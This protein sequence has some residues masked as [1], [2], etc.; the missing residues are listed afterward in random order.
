[1]KNVLI[2]TTMFA[3]AGCSANPFKSDI[4][5]IEPSLGSKSVPTWYLETPDD[6][7]TE[8]YAA[9]TGKADDMQ[10]SMD[11][12]LHDAK[13]ILGDKIG[14]QVSAETKKFIGDNAAGGDGRTI[15]ETEKVSKSGFKNINVSKYVVVQKSIFSEGSQ[16]RTYVLLRLPIEENAPPPIQEPNTFSDEDRIKSQNALENL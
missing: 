15:Q 16:F 9:A 12:A 5:K 14:T 7:K 2:A 1:M 13:I 4:T 8:I 11:K 6:S 3:L 10:F